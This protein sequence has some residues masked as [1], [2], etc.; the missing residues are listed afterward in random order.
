MSILNS[1]EETNQKYQEEKAKYV[2]DSQDIMSYAFGKFAK[3]Q[4]ELEKVVI[5]VIFFLFQKIPKFYFIDAKFYKNRKKL[6]RI[7]WENC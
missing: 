6:K 7:S 5:E 1:L 4:K 2:K 3:I